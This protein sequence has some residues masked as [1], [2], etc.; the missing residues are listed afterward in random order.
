MIYSYCKRCKAESPGEFCQQ[1]GKRATA[2]AQRD[3]WSIA[4]IPLT[5]GRIWRSAALSLLA[6]AVLLLIA[7]LGMEF[8]LGGA[9][10]AARLWRGG[11]PRLIAA[12]LPLG[13][14]VVFLFLALQGREV[15]VYFLDRDG[16]H[17]QTW[18][19]P[20][21]VK[22]WARL[23]SADRAK[24][25]PQQ[26][27]TVMHLS[28]ARHIRWADVQAV[29]YHPQRASICLYHTPHCAPMI[30]RLPSGEYD[31]AAAYVGKYCKGK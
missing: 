18:H 27:G 5:D 14:G 25:V 16:A 4:V 10:Q 29:K 31:L 23:Q 22:S 30:L 24:D 7:V 17:M 3:V 11:V 6:V 9:E 1:C 12:L 15:N 2:A 28:Q 19:A 21:L 8:I 13:I 20:S 26:D